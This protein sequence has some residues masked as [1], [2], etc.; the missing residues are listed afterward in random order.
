[1]RLQPP[2]KDYGI[3]KRRI[4]TLAL[5]STLLSLT[6]CVTMRAGSDY[7]SEADFSGYRSFVWVD[8][9]PIIE[10]RSARVEISAL[11]VR[12]VREAIEAELAGKGF[13]MGTSREASDFA[14]SF[15]VGARDMLSIDDYPSYYRSSWRWRPPYY[16]PNVDISMYTE[17]TLA[18]DVFDN[19]SRQPVWHGWARKRI[20]GADID[21]PEATINEAVEAI[22]AGFPPGR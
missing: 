10:P 3:V 6:A 22:L 15:T 14:V 16:A 12:R 4:R 21:D 8:E 11:T 2:H 17:G 20:T 9:S 5:V 1:M 19:E 18:I 7:Y 13:V